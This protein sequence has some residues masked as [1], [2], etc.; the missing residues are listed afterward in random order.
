MS[1]ADLNNDWDE[2]PFTL[3][4]N[5]NTFSQDGSSTYELN[6]K[7]AYAHFAFIN[8]EW[9]IVN[10]GRLSDAYG[11]DLDS[12]VKKDDPRLETKHMISGR[13]GSIDLATTPDPAN[14]YVPYDEFYIENRGITYLAGGPTDRHFTV[15]R[16]GDYE[17]YVGNHVYGLVGSDIVINKN[18]S[19][20]VVRS[21]AVPSASGNAEGNSISSATIVHLVAG[22]TINF[23]KTGVGYI[24]NT[25]ADRY[26]SFYIKQV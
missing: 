5:G 21:V 23:Y 25:S 14:F 3:D 6:L 1:F 11:L 12:F 13:I 20:P 17:I 16:D 26:G 9:V 24:F 22:D 18:T 2:T 19:T 8:N 10:F 7:G 4:G 15:S